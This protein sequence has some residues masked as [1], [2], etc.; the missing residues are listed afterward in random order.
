M[1]WAADCQKFI[2]YIAMLLYLFERYCMKSVNKSTKGMLQPELLSWTYRM[3]HWI[4]TPNQLFSIELLWS[5]ALSAPSFGCYW[6]QLIGKPYWSKCGHNFYQ[7]II[8]CFYLLPVKQKIPLKSQ[9][10]IKLFEREQVL[11]KRS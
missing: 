10:T 6:K 3:V 9:S 2:Q 1:S 11:R 5:K 8:N 7:Q 4:G